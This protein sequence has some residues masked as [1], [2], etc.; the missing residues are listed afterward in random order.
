MNIF[1]QRNADLVAT[2]EV[3]SN[4]P[5]EHYSDLA[6]RIL[7][8]S[9]DGIV[10]CDAEPAAG[11]GMRIVY[12]NEAFSK[13][14]GYAFDEI[15]GK[16][17]KL[18]QGP[19][20]D[21]A[22]LIR[23]RKSL[24]AWQPIREEVLNYKKNGE[25]F[26]QSLNIFPVANRQGWFTH[27]VAIQHNVT[28][29]RLAEAQVSHLAFYDQL[30]GLPNRRLVLDRLQH[31]LPTTTRKHECGALLYIDV[32]KFKMVND[33]FGHNTGDELLRQVSA[34]LTSC[35]RATDTVGRLGGDEFLVL[36]EGLSDS[37]DTSASQ[38]VGVAEKIRE[39][40][41]KP[42]HLK[43]H[44]INC[45]VSI[46]ATVFQGQGED[47][48]TLLKRADLALY[49]AKAQGRNALRFFDWDM[50]SAMDKRVAVERDLRT[51]LKKKWFSLFYQPQVD[52]S[53]RIVGAEALVRL[54][55]PVRGVVLPGEFITVAE[56]TGLIVMLGDWVINAACD[57][58]AQW[59]TI[60]VMADL[61]IAVNVSAR[62]FHQG[63]FVNSV[64]TALTRSGARASRLK[65]ELTESVAI[66]CLKD[67][68]AKINTLRGDG[69]CFCLDDFGTG[70]SSLSYL[71]Q[72]PFDQIKIDQSFVQDLPSDPDACSIVRTIIALGKT[73][74]LG[75]VAE[76]V[77]TQSQQ[78]FLEDHDCT[79]YQGYLYGQPVPVEQ[80][81]NLN[82]RKSTANRVLKGPT[83]LSQHA[84]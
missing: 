50:Q 38:V 64:R 2:D 62:Q 19:K 49:Q 60:P 13:D 30:T 47:V 42:Y 81:M 46:G 36:L 58:L 56:E 1:L 3:T 10:I 24:K 28:R 76:G 16:S 21:L 15:V 65:I 74:N 55:H 72:L 63:D 18:L 20:T 68:V 39:C 53:G 6:S 83:L 73:L 75:V 9:D 35:V 7:T 29:R 78:D 8:C 54:L 32:D 71:R 22:T 45:S 59:A 79:L 11:L 70:Y 44:T 84:K 69:V 40:V 43:E 23:I 77:E 80:L 4:L 41:A 14:S 61:S 17:P 66:V 48:E 57:Q 12:V 5:V 52:V 31:A 33:S 25:E 51:G 37:I 67:T 27:W 34:R 82:A 26:W